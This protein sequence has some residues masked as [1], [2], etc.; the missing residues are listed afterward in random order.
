MGEEST[1]DLLSS[2]EGVPEELTNV[3]DELRLSHFKQ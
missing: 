2:E 1:Y 3:E